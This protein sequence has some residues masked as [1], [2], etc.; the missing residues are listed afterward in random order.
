MPV[1]KFTPAFVASGLVCPPDKKKIEYSVADEPGLFV[2]CRASE[3]AVPTWYLR[4][5]DQAR[6]HEGRGEVND[7]HYILLSFACHCCDHTKPVQR[8]VVVVGC[9]CRGKCGIVIGEKPGSFAKNPFV[10]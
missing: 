8:G 3:R 2:E 5:A 7:G 6:G 10:T 1:I 9:P 4:G